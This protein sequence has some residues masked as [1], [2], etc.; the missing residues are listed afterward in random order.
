MP[1]LL[2]GPSLAADSLTHAAECCSEMSF[3]IPMTAQADSSNRGYHPPGSGTAKNPYK[4]VRPL[5]QHCGRCFQQN[6]AGL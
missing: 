6:T 2:D 3:E 5:W 1:Q 4:Q